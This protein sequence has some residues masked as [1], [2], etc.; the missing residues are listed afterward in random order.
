MVSW[1]RLG[2]T[3]SVDPTFTATD[4]YGD[5]LS[6]ISAAAYLVVPVPAA[7]TNVTSV[8]SGDQVQVAWVPNGVNPIAVTSSK[9][10]ATPPDS[11]ASILT[12]TVGGSA[13]TGL[14]GP[15]QPQT[16]Y[17]ITVVSSTIGGDSPASTPISVTTAGASVAPKV[18]I[19]GSDRPCQARH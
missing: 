8:Q 1:A 9:L 13:V 15:P 11:T 14:V 10:T 12:T 2:T 3:P 5:S 16:T 4:A 18:T 6:T 19:S 7:P 17:Q